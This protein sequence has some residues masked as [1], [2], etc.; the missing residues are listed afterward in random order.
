LFEK[1]HQAFS[2]LPADR[3]M[4]QYHYPFAGSLKRDLCLTMSQK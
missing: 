1:Q 3:D 2:L 4:A